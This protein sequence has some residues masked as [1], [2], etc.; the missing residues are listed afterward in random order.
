MI[1]FVQQ[2]GRRTKYKVVHVC[3]HRNA[4]ESGCPIAKFCWLQK[5]EG[6]KEDHEK[7]KQTQRHRRGSNPDFSGTNQI[8]SHQTIHSELH[9]QRHQ[10][11]NLYPHNFARPLRAEGMLHPQYG[12]T[13]WSVIGINNQE[14]E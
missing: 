7:Q 4:F 5:K 9:T 8:P 3:M 10:L 1:T 12:S 11:C 13:S 14:I 6:A 2:N